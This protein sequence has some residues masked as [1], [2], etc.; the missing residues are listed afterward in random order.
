LDEEESTDEVTR[1]RGRLRIYLGSA[2]GVGKTFAMLGEAHRRLERGTDVVIAYVEDHER[3]RTREMAEGLEV[4]PRRVV[5]YRG[6]T[7]YE[8]DLD[9]VLA[10][11]PEQALVDEFAHT[12]APG[13]RHA[14]R[15][16][17]VEELL[18]A[19]IDVI[20]T[21]NIQHLESLNDVVESITG[22]AQR[23]T[24][25][26]DIVRRAEQI[27]LVDQTPEALRR[28]MAHGNIYSAEKVDAALSNYFRVGNLSALRELAL[29]WLADRVDEGL[30]R[31]RS[32]HRIDSTWETRERVV[33]ALTGGPEGA[34]LIRRG[35]R[36]ASRGGADVLAVHVA[37]GDGLTG[38]D[39][40]LLAEQRHL[41]ESLG[42]TFHQ[43]LGD[44]V[45][46][47]LL[48]F[49]R[50][51][52][53]TQLVIGATRRG[54]VRAWLTG[55]GIGAEVIRQSG[56]IDVH[57]VTHESAGRGSAQRVASTRLGH[58][59]RVIG[60]LTAVVALALTTLF[61]AQFRTSLNLTSDLLIYLLV[62]VAVAAI[63]GLWPGVTAA[64][65]G[66]VLVNYY[67]TP[68][69]Y[70]F[71]I[72]ER[73]N[74]LAIAAFVVVATV[75]A[76]AVDRAARRES[77]AARASAEASTLAALS[78]GALSKRDSLESLLAQARDAFA[79]TGVALCDT[80]SGRRRVIAAS[81][82]ATADH[83][84]TV[85]PIRDG[86]VVT[87]RG[88]VPSADQQRVLAAYAS[89]IDAAEERQRLEREA[90]D[91]EAYAEIDRTRTALLAAVSHDLRT[92][93]A[94]LTTAVSTLA[95]NDLRLGDDERRELLDSAVRSTARLAH[96]VENLLDLSRLQAGALNVRADVVDL[97]DAIAAAL[98]ELEPA[99]RDVIVDVPEEISAVIADQV[100]LERILVNVI[101]N[102]I[103][104]SPAG[105][106]PRVQV[107]ALAGRVEIRVIDTGPGVDPTNYQEIFQPFQRLDDVSPGGVGLGLALSRGLTEAMSGVLEPEETPGGGLT[108]RLVLPN[109]ND[110]G[111]EL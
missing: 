65:V 63:G 59:R 4:V 71:T 105:A 103:R 8:M 84:D 110:D 90:H 15:W 67:F 17:D 21:L 92:P 36:V 61:L 49:S 44:D 53:A 54:R 48:T 33:V 51:E 12:N 74:A 80:S 3:A 39:P 46:E 111:G 35:F 26:D 78:T 94:A 64:I 9:A 32:D 20:T 106:P 79:L 68:P 29:L 7:L 100:L 34:T 45:P 99:S 73:N 28:R 101:S 58:R 50:A 2:P 22:I 40:A 14:K 56:A 83:F 24:V 87:L 43:V 18:D 97:S 55:P 38:A 11:R 102:A 19:G 5:R 109:A 62:T 88:P 47:A 69:L 72:A 75:V 89:Q 23:E 30:Q 13:S 82:D 86:R 6:T 91:A 107:S 41:V 16:E 66:S 77:Q 57:V 76:F 108:M 31:Y 104:H 10:R 52:N 98:D 93:L 1:R 60:F 42:G 85:V 25:P 70:T 37:R 96:L 27:E 81:G 95:S